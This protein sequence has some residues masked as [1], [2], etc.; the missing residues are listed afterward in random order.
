VVT[1]GMM[2]E[3]GGD[4]VWNDVRGWVMAYGMTSEVGGNDVLEIQQT[5][6]PP[7]TISCT[8]DTQGQG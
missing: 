8:Y 4:D 5:F 6:T 7:R 3:V 1:C 2:S